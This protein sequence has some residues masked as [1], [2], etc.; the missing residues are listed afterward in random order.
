M[1]EYA[2]RHRFHE[3]PLRFRI[4]IASG[5]V[6]AGVIGRHKFIYDL[7]GDTVNLASRM[8]SHGE[9]DKIQITR[10]T[11][12]QIKAEIPCEQRGMVSI[13]GKGEVETFWVTQNTKQE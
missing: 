5:P 4:G 7:W 6:V 9:A 10:E 12:E 8:E 3:K 1:L 11:R 13:K 2:K